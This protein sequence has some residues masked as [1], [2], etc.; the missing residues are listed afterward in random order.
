MKESIIIV[1][2]FSV[3]L[4]LMMP[5]LSAVEYNTIK[6]SYEKIINEEIEKESNILNLINNNIKYKSENLDEKKNNYILNIVHK[7]ISTEHTFLKLF[8]FIFF[9]IIIFL[10]TFIGEVGLVVLL[11]FFMGLF[12]IANAEAENLNGYDPNGPQDGGLDDPTD[13]KYFHYAAVYLTVFA[14]YIIGFYFLQSLLLFLMEPL[15]LAD[16]VRDIIFSADFIIV[17][18]YLPSIYLCLLEAFDIEDVDGDGR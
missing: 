9:S 2:L 15:D 5:N 16:L 12:M 6:S 13:I 18:R 10:L 7:F 17:L 1:S 3:I 14:L 11:F 8:L 4:L